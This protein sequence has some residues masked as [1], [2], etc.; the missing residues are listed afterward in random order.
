MASST[1]DWLLGEWISDPADQVSMRQYGSV[2]INFRPDGEL[3]YSVFLSGRAQQTVLHYR[4]ERNTIVTNQPSAPAE[5]E[6]AFDQLPDGKLR[7]AF[8]GRT[9]TYV[10]AS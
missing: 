3:V 10:R 6:T 8:A 1:P 7:L 4:V 5:E 9:S 2:S